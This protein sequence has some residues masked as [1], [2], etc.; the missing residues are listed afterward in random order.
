MDC[1]LELIWPCSE[2]KS[3]VLYRRTNSMSSICLLH[4]IGS[5]VTMSLFCNSKH[6]LRKSYR[7]VSLAPGMHAIA[8]NP[9]F[10]E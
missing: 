2:G 10:V 4:S 8:W 6:C 3:S 9:E 7:L 5:D 1:L